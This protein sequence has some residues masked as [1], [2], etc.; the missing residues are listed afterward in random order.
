MQTTVIMN[1]FNQHS[2]HLYR[3]SFSVTHRKKKGLFLFEKKRRL[4]EVARDVISFM[5]VSYIDTNI[6]NWDPIHLSVNLF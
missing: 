5:T 6:F 1:L 3:K 4:P 2:K